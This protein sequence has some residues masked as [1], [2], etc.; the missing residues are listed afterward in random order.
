MVGSYAL[1]TTCLWQK[2]L[3]VEKIHI[4]TILHKFEDL[5]IAYFFN[6]EEVDIFS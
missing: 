3:G 2:K 1:I 5:R 6:T 4:I